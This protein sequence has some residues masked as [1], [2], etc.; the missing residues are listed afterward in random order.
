M[1]N[2]LN[3]FQLLK[4]RNLLSPFRKFYY[5]DIFKFVKNPILDV[6]CGL[7]V[8]NIW[9]K[10]Q[11]YGIDKNKHLIEHCIK[12][13]EGF[14]ALRDIETQEIPFNVEFD[15]ILLINVIEHIK[16]PMSLL[17]KLKKTLAFEGRIILTY[18]YHADLLPMENNL[19]PEELK[20]IVRKSGF[21]I[22]K[23]YFK[24]FP[25]NKNYDELRIIARLQ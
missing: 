20:A 3:E 22:E 4:Q 7:G 6:G 11:Y 10:G 8:F 1:E 15:T 18:P 24:Q 21:Q 19:N 14:Y 9:L 16:K 23:C 25:L 12:N 2:E 13:N 5:L 17:E